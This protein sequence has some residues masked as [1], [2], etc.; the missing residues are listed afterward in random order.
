MER[1]ASKRMFI[2]E[3][4]IF[5][6]DGIFTAIL[7]NIST[8]GLF[9]RTNK[10]IEVGEIIEITIPLPSALPDNPQNKI[11]IDAVAVRVEEQGVAF[12]FLEMN[13]NTYKALLLF[14]D[15][16]PIALTN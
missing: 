13:D 12:R 8:G 15:P 10:P 3:T 9:L 2:D 1:R 4:A 11:V 5:T 16:N 14:T 7:E 6:K